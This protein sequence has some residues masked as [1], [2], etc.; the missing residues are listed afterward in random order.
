M[1]T[2][3]L[4]LSEVRDRCEYKLRDD[5]ASTQVDNWINDV[6]Q[7]MTAEIFFMEMYK[8]D[9]SSVKFTGDGS[10]QIFDCPEDFAAFVW[11]YSDVQDRP[12]DEV[13]PREMIEDW[14]VFDTNTQTPQAYAPLGRTGAAGANT[15]PLYQVKFDSIVPTGEDVLYGYYRLHDK[16]TADGDVILLPQNML[17]T[18]VDGVLME[19]D[20]WN[21]SDQF[22]MHRDR[23]L[24]MMNQLK[25]NQNRMPNRRRGLGRSPRNMQGRPGRVSFPSN[26]PDVHGSGLR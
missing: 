11:V 12:L 10:K 23:F 13:S 1:A 17:K 16:L 2:Y 15:V 3:T 4:T 25:K 6:V 5:R 19:S 9:T 7:Y 20:S 26:Y 8:E 18:I 24:D 14:T 21:D 22:S